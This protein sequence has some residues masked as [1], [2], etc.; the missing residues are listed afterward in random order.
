[1]P[2]GEQPEALAVAI[3][4]WNRM[5]GMDWTALDLMVDLLAVDD[6]ELL[7]DLLMLIKDHLQQNTE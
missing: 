3:L 7:I 1:M 4:A 6:I 5:G 2:Q